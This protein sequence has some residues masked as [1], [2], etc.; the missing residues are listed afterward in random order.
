M[1]CSKCKN[2]IPDNSEYCAYCGEKLNDFNAEID[3]NLFS[4]ERK[5]KIL[6]T[7]NITIF[8]FTICAVII[9]LSVFTLKTPVKK[10]IEAIENNNDVEAHTIYVEKIKGNDVLEQKTYNTVTNYIFSLYTQC[11][12]DKMEFEDAVKHLE[13]IENIK[14]EKVNI[15]DYYDMFYNLLVSKEA[16]KKG[17]KLSKSYYTLQEAINSFKQVIKEDINYDSALENIANLKIK[18]KDNA[19]SEADKLLQDGEEKKAYEL[20][21]QSK[22]VIGNDSEIN[23][24]MQNIKNKICDKAV[25]EANKLVEN[26]QYRKAI[27]RLKEDINYDVNS[28]LAALTNEI[29]YKYL[30]VY[31]KERIMDFKNIV[32]VYYNDSNNNYYISTKPDNPEYINIS[33][34]KNV[35]AVVVKGPLTAFSLRV[36]FIQDK[37]LFFNRVIFDCDGKRTEW[38]IDYSDKKTQLLYG[39]EVAEWYTSAYIDIDDEINYIG[40]IK[41]IDDLMEDIKNSKSVTVYF[42]GDGTKDH[43]MTEDEKS[44]IINLW[45]LFNI[46]NESPELIK[47]IS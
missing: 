1:Y 41:G 35:E 17:I 29:K 38:S 6:N 37:W 9:I 30:K 16:Y 15:N 44:D 22:K 24:Q 8:T 46:L 34:D 45:E 13:T 31:N 26:K 40:K 14:I 5:N 20:L 43:L 12:N 18:Y 11:N 36:G 2:E 28:K 27:K 3:E 33:R 23:E 4:Y 32:N 7:K 39:G 42:S 25:N 19:L 10:I 21:Q 47:E